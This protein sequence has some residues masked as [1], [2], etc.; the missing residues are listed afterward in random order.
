MY[1]GISVVQRLEGGQLLVY[2]SV[3]QYIFATTHYFD[4]SNVI[5]NKTDL[6]I[7]HKVRWL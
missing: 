5:F 2:T 7:I 4:K 1:Y 6:F 3:A